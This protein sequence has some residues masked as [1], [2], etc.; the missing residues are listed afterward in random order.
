MST[1]DE[2]T[3]LQS[4][5]NEGA[6]SQE[7]FEMLKKNVISESQIE[8][9]TREKIKK[10]TIKD[11]KPEEQVIP[12]VAKNAVLKKITCTN[13][14]AEL[15]FDPNTQLASCNFCNSRFEIKNSAEKSVIIPEGI[16]PFSVSKKDYESSVLEYLSKGDY[17]PVDILES[18]VFSSVNGIYLPVWYYSGKYRGNWSASSGYDYMQEY[19]VVENKKVVTK[20]RVVT[21]WRPSSGNCDGDLLVTGYAAGDYKSELVVF[22]WDT[23]LKK[24]RIKPFDSKYTIGFNLMEFELDEYKSWDKYGEEAAGHYVR[25]QVYHRIPGDHYKD[26]HIEAVYDKEKPIRVYYPVWITYYKYDGQEYYVWMDGNNPSRIFGS[27]PQDA[28]IKS[29]SEFFLN[30]FKYW[31]IVVFVWVL[32]GIISYF[33]APGGEHGVAQT[34]W[35]ERNWKGGD[36]GFWYF[37]AI[38]VVGAWGLF[39]ILG[40]M[41]KKIVINNAKNRR[42]EV[43]KRMKKNGK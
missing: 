1:I 37:R 21:D 40:I 28:S 25:S 23:V 41:Q 5:L 43:L 31:W 4:L 19:Q 29:K 14:G 8:N 32:W 30:I 17:T 27:K 22:T 24:I 18:S 34:L 15:L 11:L 3:R 35:L 33:F 12:S 7:E 13:C 20:Y 6:I 42:N 26:L 36:G 16:V 39:Y 38:F 2:L 9:S 10:E